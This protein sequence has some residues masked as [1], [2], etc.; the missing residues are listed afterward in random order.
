M[1]KGN[2]GNTDVTTESKLPFSQACENNKR[3]I[4]SILRKELQHAHHVLEVG[5]GT[6]QHSVYFAH[7]LT[8]LKW[9]TSDVRTNHEVINAWHKAY[10]ATNLYPPLVFD[11]AQK[12][13]P[14][15]PNTNESYDAVFTAN[16]V[17]IISWL[18]VENLFALTAEAL[19]V[20]G[21]F[22]VYGPFNIQGSYTS[23]GNC[24]FDMMLRQRNSESGIRDLEA[25]VALA[26]I[27]HFTL[28][29]NYDMP[30]NNQLLVF[31]K[32]V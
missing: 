27:H 2:L 29:S 32:M 10:P 26:E 30:T 1:S 19:P 3:P 17:H 6:G 11:L 18:L 7:H 16:T 15:N 31:E 23:A 5:S 22:I 13:L 8:Y 12:V 14:I 25:I 9:Q 28:Q 21:K 4:L 24:Q 20:Q